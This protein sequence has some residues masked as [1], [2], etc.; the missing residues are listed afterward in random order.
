MLS[1]QADSVRLP[2]AQ[3]FRKELDSILLAH[4]DSLYV[5]DSVR[6]LS[7]LTTPDSAVR[8]LTW[9]FPFDNGAYKFYGYL[10]YR[11]QADTGWHIQRLNDKHK[12]I[13]DPE[14]EIL[15]PGNWYGALYYDMIVHDSTITL[16]GWNGYHNQ[17]NQKVIDVLSFNASSKPAFGKK[18]FGDYK[19]SARRVILRYANDAVVSLKF[20]RILREVKRPSENAFMEGSRTEQVKQ[21]MIFFNKLDPIQPMFE[22]DYRY[23]VPLTAQM[24]GFYYENGEW[25]FVNDLVILSEKVEDNQQSSPTFHLFPGSK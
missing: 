5:W 6:N 8:L 19:D 22:G 18:I 7:V 9:L 24:Q 4:P 17:I 21:H 3:Q 15:S 16:L 11:Y 2:A 10:K 20:D 13:E 12:S 14:K 25:I 23:Y 1:R